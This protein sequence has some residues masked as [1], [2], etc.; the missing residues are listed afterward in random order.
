M[1]N[2]SFGIGGSSTFDYA[3][4][5]QVFVA[6]AI[7]TTPTIWSTAAAT[8]GPFLWNNNPA[9]TIAILGVSAAATTAETTAAIALGLTGGVQTVGLGANTALTSSAN[10]FIGGPAPTATMYATATPSAA[11]KFF[12][13][14]HTGGT[15]ALTTVGVS[16]AWVAIEGAVVVPYQSWVSVTSSGASTAAVLQIGLMWVEIIKR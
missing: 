8:G 12:F 5:G 15:G 4:L 16:P 7:I 6:Q 1:A 11:G 9:C 2:L 3:R 14:T 10:L 13:P